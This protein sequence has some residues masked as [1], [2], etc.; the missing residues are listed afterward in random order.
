VGKQYRIT[1]EMK[2]QWREGSVNLT[3][4]IGSRRLGRSYAYSYDGGLF[5]APVGFYANKGAWDLAPG[6]EHDT[7][8]DL[9]RPITPDCLFCHATRADVAAGS[10]NRYRTITHGIQCARC[11][12]T[13]SNHGSWSIRVI[14]RLRCETRFVINATSPAPFDWC[15]RASGWRI[16]VQVRI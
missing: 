8:P 4:F 1:P 6:Y 7:K 2:L 15:A 14:S 3:F 10:L 12:G 11:H 5:Q 16:F 13:S 9:N